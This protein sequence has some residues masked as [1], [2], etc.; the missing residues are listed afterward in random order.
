VARRK[1]G[2]L[3]SK[4]NAAPSIRMSNLGLIWER[5]LERKRVHSL[6]SRK[7]SRSGKSRKV[8]LVGKKGGEL[9]SAKKGK[10]S[11]KWR[12]SGTE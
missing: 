2:T 6:I 8:F 10:S 12:G 9:G 1:R 5:H 4:E 11:K 7:T 3:P